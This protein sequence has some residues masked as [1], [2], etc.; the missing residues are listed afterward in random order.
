M[1]ARHDAMISPTA[2]AKLPTRGSQE[3]VPGTEDGVSRVPSLLTMRVPWIARLCAVTLTDVVRIPAKLTG[4]T[5]KVC[6]FA[7]S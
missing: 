6:C 3:R 7:E 2:A 4:F 5:S 1:L